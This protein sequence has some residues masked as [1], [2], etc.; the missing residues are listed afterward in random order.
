MRAFTPLF[1]QKVKDYYQSLGDTP[2]ANELT[3]SRFNISIS[4][5]Y[6]WMKQEKIRNYTS[7][8]INS[9]SL[10]VDPL[11]DKAII[12]A[13]A[14]LN[15]NFDL[16]TCDPLDMSTLKKLILLAKAMLIEINHE[17]EMPKDE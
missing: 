11:T 6:N 16:R 1:R 9:S 15:Q 7:T 4:T 13:L 3:A 10:Y 2:K 17:G 14:F 8:R 12:I 5:L